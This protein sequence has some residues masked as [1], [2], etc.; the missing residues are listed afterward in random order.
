MSLVIF[1]AFTHGY[2]NSML[3]M[4]TTK[5]VEPYVSATAAVI[6]QLFIFAGCFCGII[7]SFVYHLIATLL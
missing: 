7:G 2:F 5:S 6:L 3:Q 4:L 1:F